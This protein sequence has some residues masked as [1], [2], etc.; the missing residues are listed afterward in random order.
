M[1]LKYLICVFAILLL[2]MSAVADEVTVDI[3]SSDPDYSACDQAKMN[4]DPSVCGGNAGEY[5]YKCSNCK[6]GRI[7]RGY[8]NQAQLK[9]SQDSNG[10]NSIS[11]FCVTYWAW[12]GPLLFVIV[13]GIAIGVWCFM[14]KRSAPVGVA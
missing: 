4:T 14:K 6:G 7:G 12:L 1:K 5:C 13:V 9:A 2:T 11:S 3:P 8:R 10:N